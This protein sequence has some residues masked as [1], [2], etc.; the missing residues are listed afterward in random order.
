MKKSIPYPLRWLSVILLVA[1]L[2]SCGR[3]S[4][5]TKPA[6]PV[7]TKQAT[8]T[9]DPNATPAPAGYHPIAPANCDTLV[10]GLSTALGVTAAK[11]T[12]PFE[13]TLQNKSGTGCLVTA[14]GSGANFKDFSS[15][16]DAVSS[17][18]KT[19]G[20]QPDPQFQADGP[21]ST[22][23]GFVKGKQ[24]CLLAISSGP[25]DPALCSQDEPFASC[26]AKLKPEQQNY[27]IKINCAK[28]GK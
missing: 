4:N 25:T 13:D 17:V 28:L 18:L 21:G 10:Q 23:A 16:V 9:K 7:K 19:Q 12:V 5:L 26:W 15:T 24:L 22:A 11:N 1:M 14:S 20:M 3:I 8:A 6:K 2:A 27:T